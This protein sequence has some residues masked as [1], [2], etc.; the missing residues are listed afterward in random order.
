[1]VRAKKYVCPE[2]GL[3]YTARCSNTR[4]CPGCSHEAERA[5]AHKGHEGYRHEGYACWVIKYDPTGED[6]QQGWSRFM[7]QELRDMLTAAHLTPGTVIYNTRTH[8]LYEV[9]G[10]L[11]QANVLHLVSTGG[12]Q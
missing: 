8:R 1:M 11:L 4:R 3:E 6:W 7:W 10:Q 5:R 12:S 2:C 9:Q